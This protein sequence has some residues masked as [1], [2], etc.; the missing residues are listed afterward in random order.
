MEQVAEKRL[1]RSQIFIAR[2]AKTTKQLHRSDIYLGA[3]S[4]PLLA[5]LFAFVISAPIK[6]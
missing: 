4:M 5:E 3:A 2:N 6:I 1:R